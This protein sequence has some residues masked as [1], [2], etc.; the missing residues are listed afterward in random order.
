M[1][2]S[3]CFFQHER[4]IRHLGQSWVVFFDQRFEFETQTF[5]LKRETR[6]C[7]SYTQISAINCSY[8]LHGLRKITWTIFKF[9]YVCCSSN[10]HRTDGRF[11]GHL[12]ETWQ[13]I[14][15][16]FLCVFSPKMF[17]YTRP[18][19]LASGNNKAVFHYHR[20]H[21]IIETI[22]CGIMG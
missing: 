8:I 14:L 13:S 4:R 16:K 12:H 18:K 10:F 20:M 3:F 7:R 21:F 6:T 15:F 2:W 1:S 19:E 11:D 5:P 17:N 22:T 9:E